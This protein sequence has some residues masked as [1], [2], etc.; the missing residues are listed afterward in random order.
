MKAIRVELSRRRLIGLDALIA[1]L[2]VVN[3]FLLITREEA[4]ATAPDME[5]PAFVGEMAA[6]GAQG[7]LE[8]IPSPPPPTAAPAAPAAAALPT[9][10]PVPDA[11]ADEALVQLGTI[12]IPRI[13]LNTTL[14]QGIT[15]TTIDRGP[16]HWPGTA[17][18]GQLGNV[19]IAGHR[20]THSKPFRHI[21]QMLPGDRVIFTVDGVRTEY[22]MVSNEVVTPDALRIV[23]QRPEHTATLF[24]CHPPGSARYRFVVHLRMVS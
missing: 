18:P 19:V 8:R 12:E 22:E 17:L 24:A 9:P 14:H 13:G 7:L 5:I 10:A 2:L 21:D 16:S 1:I 20:V 11:Y 6:A 15:L 23:E 3:G 4:E